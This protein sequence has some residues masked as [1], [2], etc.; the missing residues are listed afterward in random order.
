M[1]EFS[2]EE[3]FVIISNT[4]FGLDAV[5]WSCCS[6]LNTIIKSRSREWW[7]LRP[8]GCRLVKQ[9][10][11][12][13]VDP[14]LHPISDIHLLKQ[15][16]QKRVDRSSKLISKSFPFSGA[17]VLLLFFH[18]S[19]CRSIHPAVNPSISLTCSSL[20]SL[21]GT[22]GHTG[23]G[24][25]G[26]NYNCHGYLGLLGSVI[27]GH[28]VN[29]VA[30]TTTFQPW[31]WAGVSGERGVAAGSRKVEMRWRQSD[32]VMTARLSTAHDPTHAH[33][34]MGLHL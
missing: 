33:P 5:V 31:P 10:H 29:H 14:H 25:R 2:T 34:W 22:R 6:Y 20:L 4:F 24:Q 7:P 28:G 15:K 8:L 11:V 30:M 17:R 27:T 13:W 32:Q 1:A 3:N 26:A 19:V 23:R 9:C 21:N 18:P 12:Y 16:E